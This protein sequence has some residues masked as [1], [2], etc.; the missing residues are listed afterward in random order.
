MT[1]ETS[2]SMN[3]AIRAVASH[4]PAATRAA[5]LAND[6]IKAAERNGGEPLTFTEIIR[7]QLGRGTGNEDE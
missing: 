6:A 3:E 5:Q 4:G 2:Q 7:R 1:D